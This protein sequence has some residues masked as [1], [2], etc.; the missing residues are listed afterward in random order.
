MLPSICNQVPK[1]KQIVD[2]SSGGGSL[3]IRPEIPRDSNLVSRNRAEQAKEQLDQWGLT[4][5]SAKD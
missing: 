3:P 4:T 5:I 2:D 1:Q